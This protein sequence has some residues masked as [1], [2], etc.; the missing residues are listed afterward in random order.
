[1]RREYMKTKKNFLLFIIVLLIAFIASANRPASTAEAVTSNKENVQTNFDDN[2]EDEDLYTILHT[3]QETEYSDWDSID[4]P[5]MG[6]FVST[7]KSENDSKAAI[8]LGAWRNLRPTESYLWDVSMLPSSYEINCYDNDE[9]SKGWI[10]GTFNIILSYCNGIWDTS[11]ST[12]SIDEI[13]YGV[14]AVTPTLAF[15]VG[16]NGSILKYGWDSTAHNYTWTK[17]PIPS[18]NIDLYSIEVVDNGNGYTVWAIGDKD[19]SANKPTII[20]GIVTPNGSVDDYGHPLYQYTWTNVT[21]NYNTIPGT[22]FYFGIHALSKNDIWTVGG[23]A[24]K[25]IGTSMHWNGST[26]TPISAGTA[27]LYGVHFLSANNGW[28]VGEWGV[29]MHYNGS[30]WASVTSPTT[31]PLIDIGFAQNGDGWA[32]GHDGTLLKFNDGEWK[33]FDDLRTDPFDFNR[34]DFSS[35]HGWL[36]G[37]NDKVIGGQ[38]LEYDEDLWLA[39]TPATDNQLNDIAVISDNDAWAVGNKDVY[40]ATVIHWDGKH[41]Q[42]WYQ[43][44]LPLPAA[45]LYT[46]DMTNS[47]SGWAAGDPL[48]AENPAV[49]L[50]WTGRRWEPPR[51]SSPLNTRTN[52]LDLFVD[53]STGNEFG[54]AVANQGNAIAKFVQSDNYWTAN[55]AFGGV[56]YNLRGVSLVNDDAAWR[57]AAVG[58][59]QWYNYEAF[60]KFQDEG[61]NQFSWSENG[62]PSA[63]DAQTNG[64]QITNLF[65]VKIEDYSSPWGFAVGDYSERA[66]IHSF[67]GSVWSLVYCQPSCVGC[68]NP[69]RFNSVDIEEDT[70]T[71]WFGGYYTDRSLKW[72]FIAFIN[73]TTFGYATKILPANS[74]NT[75]HRPISSLQMSSDTMGWA[76]G[77]RDSGRALSTIY[78]YPYPNFTLSTDPKTVSVIPGSQESATI[79]ANA[80]GSFS[81]SINLTTYGSIPN[82]SVTLSSNMITESQTGTI[83]ISTSSSTP[84]GK[85][86]IYIYGDAIVRSGDVDLTVTRSVYLEVIVSRNKITLI[87]PPSERADKIVTIHGVNFGSD[88]GSGNYSSALNHVILAGEQLP[89]NNITQWTNSSIKVRVP[90]DVNIYP[91]GAVEDYVQVVSQGNYSNDNLFFQVEN[92]ISDV[93]IQK[94]GSNYTI[95]IIGTGFG[96]DPGFNLRNT[97]YEHVSLN[98]SQIDEGDFMTWSNNQIVFT[99]YSRPSGKL[100]VTSNGYESNIFDIDNN[101]NIYLPLLIK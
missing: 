23:D 80:L 85:Y 5:E 41:W 37:M 91:R 55:H 39:V 21:Q 65:G 25:H 68:A 96:E 14:K 79:I 72:P 10:V 49:F 16:Q 69:T 2:G 99:T 62:K 82:G 66:V 97:Q 30:S 75:W 7:E 13:L 32:V 54:W 50:Q 63:C 47:K 95:T 19:N 42:R 71:A 84:I 36:V 44:D 93:E 45:N 73:G 3:P 89:S 74:Q 8:V 6:E 98:N 101:G 78:Q 100:F 46:I 35:G 38:I 12:Q 22:Q 57:G 27:P 83:T 31:K 87:N 81:G 52:D 64:P 11:I 70:E 61:N 18:S 4:I 26:W 60:L 40:G 92:Y 94:T 77:D 56:G 43:K 86:Y 88:P 17:F 28:A 9:K 53:E 29:I 20:R 15:A 33:L 51:Y 59:N 67:N 24:T 58:R 48:V 76:V 90:D 34:L 1:M